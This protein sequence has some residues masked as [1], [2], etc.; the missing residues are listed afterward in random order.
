MKT[1][2]TICIR[3]GSQGL[4]NKNILKINKK[5]LFFFTLEQAKKS[6][7]FDKIVI[8][9]DSLKIYRLVNKYGGNAFFIR[10][11][12]LSHNKSPKI[13]VIRHALLESE[14]FYKYKFD[15]IVDLDVTSPLR[16]IQDIKKAFNKFKK[17]HSN[18]LFSVTKANKNPYFNQIEYK[19]NKYDLV[20]KSN[21]LPKRRQDSSK[22]FDMNASIYIWKR[23]TLI[24]SDNLFSKRTSIYI[25]PKERSWDIDDKIDFQF[26]KFLIKK[27]NDK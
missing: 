2:C 26:A 22:V 20:K 14:K 6:N 24:K 21:I 17:N 13:P 9:T 19:K 15:Y 10:P 12:S 11:K 1:L 4:I 18:I 25:M 8:S 27:K 3:S 23:N 16:S 7:L 5:P